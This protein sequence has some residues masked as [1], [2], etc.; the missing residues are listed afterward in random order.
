MAFRIAVPPFHRIAFAWYY[1]PL[2]PV[3]LSIFR[4]PFVQVALKFV[5]EGQ[6]DALRVFLLEKLAAMGQPESRS[7]Y[8]TQRVMLC[9]WLTEIYLK[10]LAY[11]DPNDTMAHRATTEEFQMFLSDHIED[12]RI[13]PPTTFDLL[14]SHGRRNEMLLYAKLIGD[15]D[16][17][18]AYHIQE[19]DYQKA[20]QVGP[21]Y[22]ILVPKLI[23]PSIY[24]I[25]FSTR[26]KYKAL[27]KSV[28][29]GV[30]W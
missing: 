5:N 10:R 24:S 25:L 3:G 21:T 4:F 2:T 26:P 12:L 9:T 18:V 29:T 1:L 8:K 6:E 22:N 30:W 20:L 7:Q 16:R 19:K 27:T 17:V 28:Q 13:H 23:R 11:L 14:A 15:L